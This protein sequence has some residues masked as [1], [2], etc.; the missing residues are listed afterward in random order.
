MTEPANPTLTQRLRKFLESEEGP[1]AV[2][3][4][5]LLML[6]ILVCIAGIQAVGNANAVSFQGSA[7]KLGAAINPGN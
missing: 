4:A 7:D 3:Y 1:T 5:V 6:I 2:E